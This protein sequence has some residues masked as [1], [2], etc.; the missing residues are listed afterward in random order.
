MTS[1]WLRLK[2][3]RQMLRLEEPGSMKLGPIRVQL[4]KLEMYPVSKRN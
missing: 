3:T 4:K 2:R 1:R